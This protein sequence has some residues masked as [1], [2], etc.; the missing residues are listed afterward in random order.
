MGKTRADY[1]P[2]P[3]DPKAAAWSRF[4]ALELVLTDLLRV[5]PQETPG[6]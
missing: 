2:K 6:K 4:I 3:G 5:D 1:L